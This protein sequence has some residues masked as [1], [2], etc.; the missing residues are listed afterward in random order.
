MACFF[1]AN[2]LG[3]GMGAY[4]ITFEDVVACMQATPYF[5][6]HLKNPN[7]V[8][9]FRVIYNIVRSKN[10]EDLLEGKAWDDSN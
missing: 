5:M 7:Q 6:E 4:N 9:P 2:S 8:H 1:S 3:D 10:I